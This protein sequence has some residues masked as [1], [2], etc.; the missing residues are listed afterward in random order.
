VPNSEYCCLVSPLSV[1][2]LNTEIKE[3]ETISGSRLRLPVLNSI[4]M[5]IVDITLLKC[6]G[7]LF[8]Q[9]TNL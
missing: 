5:I 3:R 9:I 7:L 6:H 1:S 8:G 4:V 2:D